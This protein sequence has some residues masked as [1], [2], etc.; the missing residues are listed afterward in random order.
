MDFI[1]GFPTTITEL[2]RYQRRF[3]CTNCAHWRAHTARIGWTWGKCRID[4]VDSKWTC[5][6]RHMDEFKASPVPAR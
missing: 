1:K 6:C 3:R 4:G 5:P 2:R